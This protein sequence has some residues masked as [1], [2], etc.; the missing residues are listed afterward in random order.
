V[1]LRLTDPQTGKPKNG[2]EDVRVLTFLA[3]GIWQQRQWADEKGEGLYEITF[4]P[5]EEGLYYIFVEVA[6]AGLAMQ[7]SPFLTLDIKGPGAR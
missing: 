2:L 4:N 5:R 3:P 7:R 6:S 1:R